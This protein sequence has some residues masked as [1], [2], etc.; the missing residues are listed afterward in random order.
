MM[1]QVKT[2]YHHDVLP[3]T[4]E[5]LRLLLA[6]RRL[7]ELLSTTPTAETTVEVSWGDVSS[8]ITICEADLDMS[9]KD[10]GLD[11]NPPCVSRCTLLGYILL[12][13]DR[14][15]SCRPPGHRF[16]CCM[17]TINVIYGPYKKGGVSTDNVLSATII[18]SPRW[19][20]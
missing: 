12:A 8:K 3:G 9:T 11:K 15:Q 4:K 14:T 2:K 17:D 7:R 10:L 16:N 13:V 18:T 5:G 6:C 1:Y 20:L 19:R